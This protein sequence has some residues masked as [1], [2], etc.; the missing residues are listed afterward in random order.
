MKVSRISP[1]NAAEKQKDELRNEKW[2]LGAEQCC[3]KSKNVEKRTNDALSCLYLR[4]GPG[5]GCCGGTG[6]IT[7]GERS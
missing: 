2:E 3:G 6:D 7:F 1:G 4:R 5:G